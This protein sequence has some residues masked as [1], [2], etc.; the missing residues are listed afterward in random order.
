[1]NEPSEQELN[2][3]QQKIADKKEWSLAIKVIVNCPR[4]GWQG[5]LADGS[6]KIGLKEPASDNR[7]NEALLKWLAS[8]LGCHS[9]DLK[10]ISGQTSRRKIVRLIR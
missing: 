3:W 7:A 8:E 2:I 6:W 1:M 9:Q 4:Q 5:Q 10:I